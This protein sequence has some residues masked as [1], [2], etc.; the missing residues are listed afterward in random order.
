MHKEKKTKI[1]REDFRSLVMCCFYSLKKLS[2]LI[3]QNSC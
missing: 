2:E 3:A 1:R